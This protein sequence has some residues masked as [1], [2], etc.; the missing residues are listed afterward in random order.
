MTPAVLVVRLDLQI[1]PQIFKK[2]KMPL[3]LFSEAWVKLIHEKNLKQ[4]IS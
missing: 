2:I 1:S 3:M 4:K